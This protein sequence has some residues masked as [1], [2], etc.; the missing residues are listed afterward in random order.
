MKFDEIGE[1]TQ[2]KLDII[3]QYAG[4][5]A[6]ILAK[7]PYLKCYYIDAFCGAGMH[8]DRNTKEEVLGSPLRALAAEEQFDKYYFIDLNGDKARFLRQVCQEHPR[9]KKCDVRTGDCGDVLA[10]LL[11]Q[12]SYEKY[13]RLLCLLDPYGLH[14]DWDIIAKMGKSRIADL[15]LN[16]PVMDMNL[17]A[18]W[19]DHEKVPQWGIDRMTRFWGDESWMNAAYQPDK[20]GGLFG[21]TPD[22]KKQ[23]NNAVAEAFRDRLLSVAEFKHVPPP[24]PM[25]NSNGATVYYLFFASQNETA[26]KIASYLLKKLGGSNVGN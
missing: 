14:L 16:F 24:I 13:E 7:Q 9:G 17:N 22:L 19:H 18:F 4:A 6:R 20:Q 12:F 10:E 3:G 23:P 8:I 26:A 11:P 25:K 15:V 5:Y 1:W 21:G 2:I